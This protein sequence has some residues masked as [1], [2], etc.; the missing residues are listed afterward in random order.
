MTSTTSTDRPTRPAPGIDE[1][2]A[3]YWDGLSEHR[4]LLQECTA[5]SRRRF[6]PMPSCPYCGD[7]GFE[8]V[9][10]DGR[11][12]VYSW[13]VVHL[14]FDPAFEADVPYVIATVDLEGGGRVVARL[15]APRESIAPDLP[16]TA[17][18]HDHDDWTELRFTAATE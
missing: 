5:C 10:S 15:E 11:G 16:V 7:P 12:T 6:P 3:F 1:D 2:S 18:Y 4:L 14:A 13:I 8:I 9:E 17:T